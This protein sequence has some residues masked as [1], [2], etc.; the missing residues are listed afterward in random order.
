MEHAID[1]LS[2]PTVS[3]ADA[4]RRLLVVAR[5]IGADELSGWIK[6]ELNGYSEDDVVPDY[7]DGSGLPIA[8][9]FDGYGGA[10]ETRRLYAYELPQ[11]LAQALD[12]FS[13]GM[14]IAELHALGSNESGHDARTE[15]PGVWLHLYR[16]AADDGRAPSM[17]M[18]TAN[19]ASVV[20]PR[21][22]ISG[23][24]DRVKT[25]AL[26]LALDIEVVSPGAGDVGGPTV[27]SE[28]ALADAVRSHLTYIFATNST[29]SVASGAGAVA[30]QVE[31]GDLKGLIDASR[32]LLSEEGIEEFRDALEAD[33]GEPAAETRSFLGRVRNGG[34]VL[35]G[36]VAT[37]A[38]YDALTA[39][40]GQAFPGFSL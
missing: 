12:G 26:D 21:T 40:V 31:V 35:A 15:L 24:I 22:Y 17:P 34:V 38:A 10:S 32:S 39:L 2:D 33:G 8:I 7:R 3:I 30:I 27:L 19:H 29:V 1:S 18:Y 5:R 20:I 13:L 6:R 14:P 36:S 25:D 37:S 11:N 23:L 9:R 28:P 4:L 16:E